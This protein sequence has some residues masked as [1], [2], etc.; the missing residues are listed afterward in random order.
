[1]KRI[2]ACA[3]FLI[4][5]SSCASTKT[6]DVI[7][8]GKVSAPKV[9]AMSGS[10]GPWVYQIEKRLRDKGF[11]IKRWASQNQTIENRD[12]ENTYIYNEATAQHVLM[13]DG[14]AENNSMQRCYG[15]GYMF[16]YINAELIDVKNNETIFHYS[17]SGYS[18]DCPP[19]SGTIFTDIANLVDNAWK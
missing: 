12:G 3:F 11:Q 10:R 2:F 17:N 13:I 14:Y 7:K 6:I 19:L 1:M 9:V 5:F 16:A 15:G 8:E 4:F 18:E